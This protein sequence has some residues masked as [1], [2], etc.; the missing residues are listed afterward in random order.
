MKRKTYKVF[1]DDGTT[2]E[3]VSPNLK[4]AI[5]FYR[6]VRC[7]MSQYHFEQHCRIELVEEGEAD[8]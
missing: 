2:M 8:A 5:L 6:K 3:V 4:E 1:D 7:G